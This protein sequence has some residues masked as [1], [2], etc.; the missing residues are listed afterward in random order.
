M[1]RL[2]LFPVCSNNA[3]NAFIGLDISTGTIWVQR[4]MMTEPGPDHPVVPPDFI[5]KKEPEWK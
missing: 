1:P 4:A 5:L 3:L 2:K